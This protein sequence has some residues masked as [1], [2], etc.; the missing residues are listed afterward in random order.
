MDVT[1][2]Q[3]MIAL[4]EEK[5][6]TKAAKKL[7]LSQ[8]A[9]SSWLNHMEDQLG[10]A[11][12]IRS[13]KGLVLT[14]AG[15][16]Y[17]DG[18]YRMM[19]VRKR[20]YAEIAD[21]LGCQKE[22]ITVSG[23]PNGGAKVFSIVFF[24]FREQFPEVSLQFLEA[25]NQE[26]MNMVREGRADFGIC[27]SLDTDS[28]DFE[29]LSASERELVVMLPSHHRLGY[30]ASGL[31]AGARLPSVSLEALSD[32]PFIM[33]GREMSY[34][35]GLIHLFEQAHFYPKVLFQSANVRLLYQI[36][37]N[38]N[39]AAVLPRYLFS[40]LDPVSPFSLKPRFTHFSSVICRKGIE[41]TPAKRK[42]AELLARY[43]A[44]E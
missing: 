4:A 32:T 11:L 20:V 3:Y 26:T 1:D 13:K 10:T 30:D 25:Y 40:P 36:V 28:P 17:L 19:Q 33:P 43:G 14:L 34:Y 24:I 9:L 7:G 41:M 23:T 37:K 27:S 39:G 15:R 44:A 31:K 38:G 18:A 2:Q 6:I 8:P 16:I 21:A 5:S 29:Y 35:D 12:V 22:V 42:L